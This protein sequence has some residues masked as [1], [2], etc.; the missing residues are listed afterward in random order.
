MDTKRRIDDGPGILARLAEI[1]YGAQAVL[2]PAP[3]DDHSA[4]LLCEPCGLE[5]ILM[6]A[7]DYPHH[8]G[9]WPHS[10]Q[11]TM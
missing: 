8:E 2:Y 6:F 5:N 11:R 10:A 7:N 9:T 4:L 3:G 1:E